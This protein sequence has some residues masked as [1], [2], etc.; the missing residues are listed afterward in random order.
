MRKFYNKF[1]VLYFSCLT[2]I[3]F[4]E[5]VTY[6][7]I[8][9]SDIKEK[10]K[11]S[12]E[13]ILSEQLF[14]HTDRNAYVTGEQV[15]FKVYYFLNATFNKDS[16][17]KIVYLELVDENGQS[18]AVGK[19]PIE[20]GLANGHLSIPLGINSGYYT[21]YAYTKWMMNFEKDYFFKKKI[22]IVNPESKLK[23]L[24]TNQSESENI[25]LKF[26][27]KDGALN[28]DTINTTTVIAT[29][30]YGEIVEQ[31]LTI[32]DQ[33]NN[34]ISEFKTPGCFDYKPEQ[35]KEYKAII[36]KNNG[37]PLVFKLPKS[38]NPGIKASFIQLAE[39][40]LRINI[41]LF[42]ENNPDNKDL[43][44]LIENR[45]L[46]YKQ[47]NVYFSN[48]KYQVD[49]PQNELMQGMNLIYIKNKKNLI[50]YKNAYV[51]EL[52]N[53]FQIEISLNKDIFHPRERVD[54]KIKT[55]SPL[56]NFKNARLSV[57]VAKYDFINNDSINISDYLNY[58]SIR[59][60][61]KDLLSIVG[62]SN[63]LFSLNSDSIEH[64][65]EITYL[66]EMHGFIISGTIL[67]T[68]TNKPIPNTNI[69]LSTL[70]NHIDV[71]NTFSKSDGKFYFLLNEKVKNTDIVVQPEDQ[72]LK[73]FKIIFDKE[74]VSNYPPDD[75][76]RLRENKFNK[77]FLEELV[78]SCQIKNQFFPIPQSNTAIQKNTTVFY[79]KA[80]STYSFQKFIDLPTFEEY[81]VEIFYGTKIVRDK[82]NKQIK[83]SYSNKKLELSQSPL[84][85]LDGIP[86]FDIDK[87]IS[88]HPSK[89][90]KVEIINN[91]YVLG[92][93]VYGGI[94]HLY[95]KNKNFASLINTNNL[96]MD[97]F[98]GFTEKNNFSEIR[99]SDE[100]T[101]KSRKADYRNTLYW[102]P[103]ITTNE[104]G[105]AII[106][107]YTSDEKGKFLISIE[108]VGE[109]G[110][111]VS[112]QQVLK[113]E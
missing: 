33:D 11:F 15:L 81:F 73:N 101:L 90:D 108:G 7:Q 71:Q 62:K 63:I 92:G 49:I 26:Y 87:F 72:S 82:N 25:L 22:F 8:Y 12:K 80:D 64:S 79:G 34:L 40:Y 77:K 52:D 88:I 74:F 57:S 84:I 28:A 36:T 31:N 96:T 55:I 51:K 93:I 66:P 18:Q 85:L 111:I 104:N 3:S 44:I 83:L 27:T 9:T 46:I 14:L 32:V 41:Q 76:N 58:S 20:C 4:S 98:S 13:L 100:T 107:F 91:H 56:Y 113:V 24:K 86:V 112:K 42:N 30:Y 23:I 102:N 89:I 16:L 5:I 39:G 45:G 68:Q 69:Y 54:F 43:K 50:I 29:D 17:S 95:T 61:N 60:K 65:S 99:Y 106:S 1:F 21:I 109:N 78:I 6:S 35:N 105:E 103:E 38:A 75:Q 67:S 37:S 10:F 48:N 70:S 47:I 59:D 110:A 19:Y 94:I 53:K 2:I 97:K